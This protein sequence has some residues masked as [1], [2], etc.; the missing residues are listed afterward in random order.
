VSRHAPLV[1][2]LADRLRG[3]EVK[4][5]VYFHTDHFEPWRT[6]GRAPA[7]GPETAE[8]IGDFCD[9][10]QRIDFARRLTLFYKP[11]LNYALRR[12]EELTRAHPDDLVGFLPRSQDEERYGGEA[13]REVATAT[14][15]DIQLHIHH[16][17]YTATTDH[18]DPE[19]IA[20][21]ATPLGRSLDA[22][23]VELAIQLN[24]QII[25]RESGR[26]PAARWFFVHGHWALNASD[27][28]S[29]T[30]TNEI[31]ILLRN[32]CRGD[33]TFPAGRPH[34]NPRI[35][36]PYL[37]SPFDA[38]KGYDRPEADP[39]IACGNAAAAAHKFLIWG[40]ALNSVQCS[41]DYMAQSSRRQIENTEKAAT[42]LVDSGYVA[43]GQL[44]IKTHAHSMHGYY[45]EHTRTPV[46]PHQY[47]ATQTLLSVIFDAAAEAGVEIRF[48]TVPEVYDALL[49]VAQKPEVDLAATYL[50]PDG[51]L[52]GRKWRIGWRGAKTSGAAAELRPARP[53][54]LDPRRATELVRDTA[55]GVL[56][57]RIES[58]GVD[59]SGAYAHYSTMLE[60]GFDI[61]PGE[62]R[63]LDI[64]R[65]RVP[66][67][68]A[69]HEIGSGI[70]VLPFLLAL[71]GLPSVGIE[72]D[73][74]RHATASAIWSAL[75]SHREVGDLPC[76]LVHGRF[77][78]AATGDDPAN[79]IAIL[80][81]FIS[82][83]TPQQVAAIHAGLRRYRYVLI[84]LRR[85]CV[86]R[87]AP[88]AQ[89]ALL[90]ALRAQGFA[91]VD[92]PVR[93]GDAALVLLRNEAGPMRP[94][95]WTRLA[96]AVTKRT[97]A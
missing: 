89:A 54:P 84:D 77:P 51:V 53:G 25:A 93:V 21:F 38:P 82:T 87:D 57:R 6:V 81:D 44:F 12:G 19:A 10:T 40:S 46:F 37:C 52:S 68:D 59:G 4:S 34:T 91:A 92:E 75:K 13:M 43:G 8:A 88:D 24:R 56:R 48:L 58:L 2:K 42:D 78:A 26:S 36:V 76:R 5:L 66:R 73:K 80:T 49:G 83:Q 18:T 17:Y 71:R 95:F 96:G 33:F 9:V 31:D 64:M 15:H 39:E 14:S 55:S 1:R 29:C 67:L 65:D 32:G 94:A 90:D 72:A 85:F 22:Q 61:P 62:T 3:R 79:A 74:R 30:V 27:E 70:G 97:A 69:Y 50:K 11:N 63:V 20:W 28:T 7:I 47:P 41:L 86:V 16:E 60:R 45:F 23:R 35:R